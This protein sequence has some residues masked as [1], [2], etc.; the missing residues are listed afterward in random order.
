MS[1]LLSPGL[2]CNHSNGLV[3]LR[4]LSHWLPPTDFQDLVRGS[5]ESLKL[6][7]GP[8]PLKLKFNEKSSEISGNKTGKKTSV[9]PN[10]NP[11]EQLRSDGL[12]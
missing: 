1:Y 4:L 5:S 11:T 7:S 6:L 9:P 10:T 2:F 8:K 12:A 3:F